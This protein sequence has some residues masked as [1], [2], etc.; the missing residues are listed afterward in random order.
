MQDLYGL[1]R[2]ARKSAS[3]LC[4]SS[5]E[6]RTEAVKLMAEYL[7]KDS[8]HILAANELD[9]LRARASNQSS[10]LLDRLTLTPNRIETIS[11]GLKQVALL[12][13]PV[14]EIIET[15]KRPNGLI[16][17]KTRVPLGVVGVIYEARPNVTA[18]V[19]ALC[20][21]AGNAVLLRGSSSTLMSNI[22]ITA[23]LQRALT[24]AQ[25]PASAIQ[26]VK[27]PARIATDTMLK[28]K[29]YIDVLI[30]RGGSELIEYVTTNSTIPVIQTGAGV[31]HIYVD[32]LSEPA[33]VERIVLNAKTQRPAVCNSVETLLVHE[34][35]A[36]LHL[37][38]LVDILHKQGVKIRACEQTYRLIAGLQLASM[39][40]WK[41]E[42]LD[43]VLNMKIV[44]CL[45]EAIEHIQL[46]GTNHSEC[47]ITEDAARA[48]T[49]LSVVD[50][51]VVYHNASTRFTDGFEFGLGA[52]IGISTQKLHARGPMG[53]KEL[54][55]YKYKVYGQGQARY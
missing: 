50:A 23:A 36:R 32:E 3:V 26:L 53:L 21:R 40:D 41:T 6:Q 34:A 45:E 33:M 25:L 27:D 8:E 24:A 55:S 54:T 28:L 29:G 47:I 19:A 1:A 20:I 51:A 12:H 38:K 46:Y 48:N 9:L 7:L 37:C 39:L 30:P 31:C 49:F 10:A 13:D 11:K 4:L 44:S 35:W 2:D 16:I 43:L 15:L 14:G 18:D 17:T 42:Y 22:A 52:E 5:S